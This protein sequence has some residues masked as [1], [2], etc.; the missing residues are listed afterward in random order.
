MRYVKY[1]VDYLKKFY[2][3][4]K[5]RFEKVVFMIGAVCK[6][7]RKKSNIYNP[8]I[9]VLGEETDSSAHTSHT[10]RRPRASFEGRKLAIL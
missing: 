5:T 4:S 8:S 10:L 9:C 3:V 6:M 7:M 1:T 2:S